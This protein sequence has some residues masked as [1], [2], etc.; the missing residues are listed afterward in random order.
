[1][2][3]EVAIICSRADPASLN[4]FERLLEL[5]PWQEEEGYWFRGAFR[6]LIHDERQSTL[7]GLD[8]RLT[9]LGLH[10]EMVVFPCRHESKAALPWFGGHFTGI[11]QE[12][13]GNSRLS[14]AAPAGLRSFLHNI[15][16]LRV[17]GYIISAEA[18]H[19]GPVDMK[20][21]CF[22]AEIGSTKEQWSDKKAGE[23]VA[24]AI[25][26]LQPEELPVFLGFGGGHYV[27]R[28]TELIFGS[29]IAFGHLF[30]TYQIA[31]L[32]RDVIDDARSK[33]GADYA[34]IDRKSLRSEDRK[35]IVG[36]LEE[37]DL[38]ML[39]SREIRAQFPV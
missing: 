24:R 19:H 37:L 29:A 38:P 17:P 18:T 7:S 11:L 39:R 5:E 22:F 28:Q 36:I 26:A 3:G 8:N 2:L 4:I 15:A 21:P 27:Q 34:Y 6:L 14:A 23:A 32:N 1:L 35:R 10:P 12:G 33:S 13:H 31:G 30:S 20:T 25:M 9:D 16:A